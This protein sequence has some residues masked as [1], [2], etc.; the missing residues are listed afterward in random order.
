[1]LVISTEFFKGTNFC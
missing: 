1:L